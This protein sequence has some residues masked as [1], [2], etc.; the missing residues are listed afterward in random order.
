MSMALGVL[1]RSA[2]FVKC[3]KGSASV[4]RLFAHSLYQAEPKLGAC[5]EVAEWLGDLGHLDDAV[6]AEADC[7]TATGSDQMLTA[8]RARLGQAHVP[9]VWPRNQLRVRGQPRAV[10]P[11]R[12]RRGRSRRGGRCGLEQLGSLSPHVIY[13]QQGANKH[14]N[15][16]RSFSPR[17]WP[18]GKPVSLEGI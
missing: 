6:F 4:P 10:G 13:V 7:V 8:I 9:G 12:E 17:N 16:S 1:T 5:L 3:A 2:Q 15:D 11:P 14:W 18:A